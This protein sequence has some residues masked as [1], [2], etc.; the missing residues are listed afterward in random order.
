MATPTRNTSPHEQERR[1]RVIARAYIAAVIAA[2][3]GFIVL[4]VFVDT[5]HIFKF[6]VA[7]TRTLQSV[8]VALYRWVMVHESDPGYEPLS[9]LTYLAM[10]AL[11]FATRLR[12]AAFVAVISSLLA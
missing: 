4:A 9:A 6:D 1:G 5:Q 3:L 7:I 12:V 8:H 11:L 10:F 2:V